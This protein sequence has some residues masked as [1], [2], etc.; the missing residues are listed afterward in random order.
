MGEID[1]VVRAE[2]VILEMMFDT[3]DMVITEFFAEHGDLQFFCIDLLI[4]HAG[5]AKA[6]DQLCNSDFH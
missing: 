4:G 1:E 5:I 6:R 3:E 2:R